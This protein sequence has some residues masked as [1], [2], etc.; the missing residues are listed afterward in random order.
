MRWRGNDRPSGL[1]DNTVDPPAKPARGGSIRLRIVLLILLITVPVS[2]ERVLSLMAD[3]AERIMDT[4]TMLHDMAVRAAL[5][6][7]E[8]LVSA[9]AMLEVLSR[10]ADWLLA[11]PAACQRL[12]ERLN[13]EVSGV[14]GLYLAAPDGRVVCASSRATVGRNVS[15]RPYFQR[16]LASRQPVLSDLFRGSSLLASLVLSKAER[17]DNQR[18]IAVVAAGLDLQW[19]SRIAA[20][21]GASAGVTVD[22]IDSAGTSLVRY[23]PSPDIVGRNF[24]DAPLVRATVGRDEGHARVEGLDGVRR[25]VAFA[26]FGG[27]DVRIVLGMD[28]AAILAPIDREILSSVLL[29]FSV[30]LAVLVISWFA[31]DRLVVLPIRR[32]AQQVSSLGAGDGPEASLQPE[33]LH[34]VGVQEFAPLVRAFGDLGR[35]LN[36]RTEALRMLN[37]RLT[38]LARTDGLTGLANR[39]TFDVQ[40]SEDWVRTRET[41]QPLGVLMIDV[42]HFKPYNDTLG[43]LAGDEALRAVARMLIAAVAGTPY[44]V[45]RYGGEEFVVLM[46]GA[47]RDAAE[48]I[49][50]DVRRLVETLEIV[51]PSAAYR[52]LTVSVGVAVAMPL[53]GDSPDALLAA[54]DQALYEAKAAGRNRVVMAASALSEG[55]RKR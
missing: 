2:V 35:R 13:S 5:A 10:Q 51:H 53:E 50:Q 6:Q 24:A 55:A 20:E 9:S 7:Q 40:L 14:Q 25:Y 46:P 48:A 54:A 41:G 47:G 39:R 36:E 45:A 23:P 38:A 42:D 33:A 1:A 31:A 26:R 12:M 52:R 28:E 18:V 29:H 19:L 15:E 16:A 37:G 11:D 17:D 34:D 22:V 43:H 21:T 49:A 4:Q 3:R 8:V 30:V 27:T 44:L 32:L